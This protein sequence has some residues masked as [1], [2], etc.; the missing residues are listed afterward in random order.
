MSDI[1]C[2]TNRRLMP[3]EAIFLRQIERIARCHPAG[4]ILRE[5]DLT[6]KEYRVLA[7][8]VM[9]ICERYGT[10]CILHGFADTA[11]ELGADAIHLPIS[12]LCAA[13]PEKREKFHVLGASCHSAEDAR[14]AQALGCTYIT[15]GH[16]FDTDCKAGLP[17][18]G[19]DFLREV[20]ES[21]DLPVFA[22]GGINKDHISDI[23]RAG[24]AGACVMSGC[25]QCE[26]AEEYL[27]GFSGRF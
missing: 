3:G 27:S 10:Q 26:D 16:I 18:R 2:V 24:A 14:E 7:R 11:L 15:A 22:I 8:R 21:T 17:G 25:M 5:K 23:R 12:F 6:E 13:A 20:C 19:L 9:Q 4:I 1:L